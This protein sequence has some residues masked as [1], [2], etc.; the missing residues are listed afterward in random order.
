MPQASHLKVELPEGGWQ[1]KGT[2]GGDV[3][4]KCEDGRSLEVMIGPYAGDTVIVEK[5]G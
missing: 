2:L 4:A 5:A 1:L 3:M